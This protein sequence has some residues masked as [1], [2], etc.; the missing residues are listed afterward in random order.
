M[1]DAELLAEIEAVEPE[2][3]TKGKAFARGAM[4]G[5]SL[6]LAD[7]AAGG[8]AALSSS[9]SAPWQRTPGPRALA[10]L[11]PG[12]PYPE[13]A[14][15]WFAEN[16]PDLAAAQSAE[17][18]RQAAPEAYAAERDK[19][20]AANEQ[21]RKD[22]RW[23]YLGGQVAGSLPIGAATAG[24]GIHGAAGLGAVQGAGYS[25]A[26]GAGLVGDTALGAGLGVAGHLAGQTLGKA[27]AGAAKFAQERLARALAKETARAAETKV[28]A[29]Q[30]AAGSLGGA[31]AEANRVVEA[32]RQLLDEPNLTAEQR[33]LLASLK[34]TP[35]YAAAVQSL[36]KSLEKR[37]PD[38]ADKVTRAESALAAAQGG[39]T[40][41][42]MAA[43]GVSKGTAWSRGI[44][45]RLARYGPPVAA[46]AVGS[47][48]G[49]A[50]GAAVGALAGAGMRPALRA[51]LRG[52]ADPAVQTALWSPVNS[53]ASAGASEGG[54]V[55]TQALARA[56]AMGG[57]PAAS[58]SLTEYLRKTKEDREAE[59][60]LERLLR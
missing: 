38:V 13:A 18:G 39:K 20:R 41:S 33:A 11:Y 28:A 22:H 46:S 44:K 3:T 36:A 50:P 53:A 26:D 60:E 30:S 42:E 59:A 12:V 15:R 52:I 29:I 7:E 51:T 37:L 57:F 48:L 27:A 25:D 43:E 31:R 58:A 24:A 23:S 56:G 14:Q 35:A 10:R 6:G 45:P 21:A 40:V 5:G 55:L 4:Q 32:I 9:A 17:A 1:T 54:R 16:R 34:D 2:K 19:Q 47:M 8:V 49:G